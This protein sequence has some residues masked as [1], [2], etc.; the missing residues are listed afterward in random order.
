VR[1]DFSSSISQAL[2]GPEVTI[3]TYL[4]ELGLF[5]N[6]ASFDKKGTNITFT[7]KNSDSDVI[8]YN[9]I[10]RNKY[11]Y[12]DANDDSVIDEDEALTSLTIKGKILTIRMDL[13]DFGKDLF[14]ETDY[15]DY[16]LEIK[17]QRT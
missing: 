12:I 13:N 1:I 17:M 16:W 5:M 9:I 14:G 6:R 10:K 15:D 7:S 8:T 2:G 3:E 11:L 4:V